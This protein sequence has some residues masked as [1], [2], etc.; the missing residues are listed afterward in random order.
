MEDAEGNPRN[1]GNRIGNTG[2][3]SGSGDGIKL[4]IEGGEGGWNGFGIGGKIVGGDWNGF[5]GNGIP[6]N[7]GGDGTSWFCGIT[8]PPV[9]SS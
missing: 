5:G 9:V 6:K 1:E 2:G 8:V 7:D 4:G 3:G